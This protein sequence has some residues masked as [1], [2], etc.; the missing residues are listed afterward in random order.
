MKKNTLWW[1][2]FS[3]AVILIL[4]LTARTASSTIKVSEPEEIKLPLKPILTHQQEIWLSALEWCESRG[5]KS[6]INPKDKDGTASYYSW[7]FKP[8]TFKNLG[9]LY[10]VLPKETTDKQ[11]PELLKDYQLQKDIVGF[12]ILDKTTNWSQQFPDCTKNKIGRPPKA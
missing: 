2:L 3:T 9:I 7:Q 5:V 1:L 8:S 6:A 12:M 11:I 10:G 4:I